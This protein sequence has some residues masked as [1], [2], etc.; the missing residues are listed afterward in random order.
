MKFAIVAVGYN[1]VESLKRLIGSLQNADY[2]GDVVSL[3]I[4]IDNSGEDAVEQYAS[5]VAWPFGE[6]IIKTYPERMGLRKHI[7]TCG[8]Y[9]YNY[10]AIAVIEDDIYVSPAFYRFMKQSVRYYEN[11]MNIAGISL[12]SHLWNENVQRPFCPEKRAYDIYFLQYAQSWGQIWM[13]KQWKMFRDWYENHSGEIE[14]DNKT[15]KHI[16]QWA[17][18]SWLKYHIKYC[19]E[20]NKYFVYPY[21]S[22][23][24]NFVEVGQHCKTSNKIYQVP[25]DYE[26]FRDFF[27][28]PYGSTEVPY[29]DAFFE[30][31]IDPADIKL[32]DRVMVDLYGAK[33]CGPERY[34]I[35]TRRLDYKIVK[36]YGLHLRPQEMNV[37]LDIPGEDI[38]LYDT[39]QQAKNTIN[40][41]FS[42][43]RWDYDSRVFDYKYIMK[44]LAKVIR[45]KIIKRK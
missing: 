42:M 44:V 2:E 5:T 13:P 28:P 34:I 41:K 25:M 33:N 39:K 23:S 35:S 43:L 17:K 37:F 31:Q 29:Y 36:K 24:T 12:Y 11:D 7:L 32:D 21:L 10:D 14:A 38:F 6:L 18:T 9:V 4:S 3:I 40:T 8:D 16:T 27:L 15:P 45:D 30:R 19:I 26:N 1:R 20:N 22:F